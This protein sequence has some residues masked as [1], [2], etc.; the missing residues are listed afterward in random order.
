MKLRNFYNAFL[1]TKC[2]LFTRHQPYFRITQL[3]KDSWVVLGCKYCYTTSA[4][5]LANGTSNVNNRAK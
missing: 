4:G 5:K 2:E 3:N 1:S